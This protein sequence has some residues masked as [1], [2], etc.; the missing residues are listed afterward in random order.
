MV[1]MGLVWGISGYIILKNFLGKSSLFRVL[2]GLWPLCSGTLVKPEH[3]RLF[4]VPQKPY[5]CTGT[6][7]D[8][9]K[10]NSKKILEKSLKFIFSF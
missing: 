10:E 1:E 8:Q 7:R 9:V 3:N 5:M 6:L 4:Y 2:G